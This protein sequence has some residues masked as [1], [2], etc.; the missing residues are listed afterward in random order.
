MSS[1]M[2]GNLQTIVKHGVAIISRHRFKYVKEQGKTSKILLDVMIGN[3]R[4]VFFKKPVVQDIF[5]TPKTEM[6]A[7][8]GLRKNIRSTILKGA[9]P[10]SKGC[11]GYKIHA[12]GFLWFPVNLLLWGLDKLAIGDKSLWA[13]L[14]TSRLPKLA[15]P[16][17]RDTRTGDMV[18]VCMLPAEEAKYEITVKFDS[19]EVTFEVTVSAAPWDIAKDYFAGDA[20]VHT[21]YSWTA[22]GIH[23]PNGPLVETRGYQALSKGLR[24]MFITDY[25]TQFFSSHAKGGIRHYESKEHPP[26][27][28]RKNLNNSYGKYYDEVHDRM[29]L[30]KHVVWNDRSQEIEEINEKIKK[31]FDEDKITQCDCEDEANRKNLCHDNVL[32]FRG[33]EVPSNTDSHTLVLAQRDFEG[34]NWTQAG[35]VRSEQPDTLLWSYFGSFL[36][37]FLK[38]APFYSYDHDDPTLDPAM[39]ISEYEGYDGHPFCYREK[40]LTSHSSFR[41]KPFM[42]AAHPKL[43]AYPYVGFELMPTVGGF[44]P[45]GKS[46]ARG[47]NIIGFEI[48][49]EPPQ[50]VKEDNLGVLIQR[51][52]P[53]R[54]AKP[55]VM[56]IWNM[57][58]WN[59]FYDSIRNGKFL[60]ALA[61]SDAHLQTISGNN[62]F[63][64]TKTYAHIPLEKR[65]EFSGSDELSFGSIIDAIEKG[66]CTCAST[67]DFGTI[68]LFDKFHPG[69]FVDVRSG[70]DL[71]FAVHFAS[72]YKKRRYKGTIL[73]I[74]H[75]PPHKEGFS[76][77]DEFLELAAKNLEK[78]N[79]EFFFDGQFPH[80]IV[81]KN[82]DR[83]YPGET[84]DAYRMTCDGA[85]TCYVAEIVFE[86]EYGKTS[87]YCNPI[88]VKMRNDLTKSH[89]GCKFD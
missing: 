56:A 81:I 6:P 34:A 31:L 67:G 59:E 36:A 45:K 30:R 23:I 80:R 68:I 22:P 17:H 47:G 73:H 44:V 72:G 46:H 87:V 19:F 28:K 49:E 52:M 51:C 37:F 25:S 76:N 29:L 84:K 20:H 43:P 24:W 85:A 64:L 9:M 27:Q 58:L 2:R 38:K 54:I 78:F 50:K 55:E 62:K 60:V 8:I 61:N 14:V 21:D 33:E 40:D 79:Q 63:G 26:E 69:S 86:D 83:L 4:P 66:S 53:A 41:H 10:K 32:I 70:F 3:L 42:I 11:E 13:F 12:L 18:P 1:Y 7:Y 65:R 77:K 89:V 39:R 74:M 88:F 82:G 71:E 15:Y 75:R 57:Y 5:A 35:R 16:G 48:F